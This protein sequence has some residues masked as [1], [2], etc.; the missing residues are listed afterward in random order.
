[1]DEQQKCHCWHPSERGADR[2]YGTKECEPCVC[3]GNRAQCDFYPEL[4]KKAFAKVGVYDTGDMWCQA[5]NNGLAY[6]SGDVI[7][8]SA[9]GLRDRHSGEEIPIGICGGIDSLMRMQWKE[10]KT[11]T[12]E[13]AE[14]VLGVLIVD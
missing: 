2:C 4:R 13:F 11:M 6:Y 10:Y 12:R 1:M 14:Q 8:S 7:Y 9:T 5:Q 3:G